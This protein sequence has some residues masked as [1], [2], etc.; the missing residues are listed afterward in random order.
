MCS[1]LED[2]H[3][4]TRFP[5]DVLTIV[6][7]YS[8]QCEAW[9]KMACKRGHVDAC[10]FL[11]KMQLPLPIVKEGLVLACSKGRVAILKTMS[12]SVISCAKPLFRMASRCGHVNVLEYMSSVLPHEHVANYAHQSFYGA[13]AHGHLAVVQFLAPYLTP[14]QMQN[15]YRDND[16]VIDGHFSDTLAVACR[17][18]HLRV[19]QFLMGVLRRNFLEENTVFFAWACVSGNLQLVK[20]VLDHVPN[21]QRSSAWMEG[22]QYACRHQQSNTIAFLMVK[23]ASPQSV[24]L[25]FE[26]CAYDRRHRGPCI[27]ASFCEID[28][29]TE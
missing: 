26:T 28:A 9:F 15:E 13:C 27:L 12:L 8:D 7:T 29:N 23:C 17:Y 10:N 16:G 24:E 11:L 25:L 18:G 1:R 3:R 22:I 2:F 14:E 19:V 4:I 6:F 5:S 21:K 20:F